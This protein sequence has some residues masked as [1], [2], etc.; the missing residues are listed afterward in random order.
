MSKFNKTLGLDEATRLDVVSSTVSYL[1]K[2]VPSSLT[3]AA[4]WKI[5]RLTS[6]AGGNITTEYVDNGKYTQI[7]DDRA[8]LSYS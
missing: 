8:S 2:A 1:G 5:S 4:V 3:S 7:W 6:T